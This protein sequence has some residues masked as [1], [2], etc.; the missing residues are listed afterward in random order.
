MHPND[1]SQLVVP[2]GLCVAQH[3]ALERR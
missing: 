3:K 1:Q 2:G